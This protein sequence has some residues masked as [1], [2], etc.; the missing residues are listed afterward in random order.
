MLKQK[1]EQAATPG[2]KKFVD[3]INKPTTRADKQKEESNDIRQKKG[4]RKAKEKAG[5]HNT[6]P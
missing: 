6:S 5:K 3:F 1:A 2:P 4:K